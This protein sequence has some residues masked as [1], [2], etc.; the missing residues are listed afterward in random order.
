MI[1]RYIIWG[2]NYAY[3]ERPRRIIDAGERS[4]LTRHY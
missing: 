4:P 1:R 2:N 3:H